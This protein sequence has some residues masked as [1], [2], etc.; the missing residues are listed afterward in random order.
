[1][2][3]QPK[4]LDFKNKLKKKRK[5]VETEAEVEKLYSVL[6][7]G[8]TGDQIA[9]R[10]MFDAN[11]ERLSS[12]KLTS[13]EFNP[14]YKMFLTSSLDTTLALFKVSFGHFS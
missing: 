9:L 1:M 7:P 11:R 8:S 4:A 14:Q 12:D 6:D 10:R 13:V 5:D 3:R 2:F